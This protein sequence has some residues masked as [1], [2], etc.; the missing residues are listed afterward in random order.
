MENN[1]NINKYLS[2]RK[3]WEINARVR[4][5]DESY[6]LNLSN[7][8]FK[9][10]ICWHLPSYSNIL[11]HHELQEIS[12]L[13]K[14][15]IMGTQLLEFVIKTTRFEIEYVNKVASKLALGD[16]NF[17]IPQVMKLDA[18][19]IYTDEGYHAY[20]SQKI[21]DQIIEYYGVKDDLIPFTNNFFNNL[22]YILHRGSTS[23]KDLALLACVIVS[24]SMIVSDIA[25]EMKDVV[26]EPIRLMFKNH[27]ID[28]AF[29]GKYFLTLFNMIWQQLSDA[30]RIIFADYICEFITIFGKPRTDIYKYSLKVLGFDDN[31]INSIINEMY[32]TKEWRIDR[33]KAKMSQILS[34]LDQNKAFENLP[35]K[36]KFADRNYI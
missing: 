20:F 1:S 10:D 14:K 21:A 15:F 13:S 24:E 9:D 16:L 29:H 11:N 18:L 36:I 8:N 6:D 27:M 31:K 2:T 34:A 33:V 25:S 28:E 22:D 3:D 7:A 23:D 12:Y 30:E 35:I 19:K 4:N 17:N 32:D 5:C 26:Y